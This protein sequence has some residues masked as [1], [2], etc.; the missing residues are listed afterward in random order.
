MAREATAE[1]KAEAAR[2]HIQSALGGP[3]IENPR[4]SFR[5]RTVIYRQQSNGRV[6]LALKIRRGLF[7]QPL[8]ESCAA[9]FAVAFRKK[10]APR[11]VLVRG[12]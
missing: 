7:P 12:S 2:R 8:Q 5:G 9:G 11:T 10:E 4:V 6:G 1:G 3:N